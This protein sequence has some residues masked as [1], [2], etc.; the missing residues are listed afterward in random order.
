MTQ[1]MLIKEAVCSVIFCS[2]VN[3]MAN[4]TLLRQRRSSSVEHFSQ[5]FLQG[6]IITAETAW[7]VHHYTFSLVLEVPQQLKQVHWCHKICGPNQENGTPLLPPLHDF[8]M[9]ILDTKSWPVYIEPVLQEWKV[10]AAIYLSR[11]E[12]NTSQGQLRL[13]DGCYTDGWLCYHD[14]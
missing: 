12:N 2:T 13:Y 14:I 6:F 11:L 5:N 1:S 8:P 9:S 10:P 3:V 4:L 7:R